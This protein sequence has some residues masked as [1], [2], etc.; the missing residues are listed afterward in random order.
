[1][2]NHRTHRHQRLYVTG[3]LDSNNAE[4]PGG[5]VVFDHKA[6]HIAEA[7][8]GAQECVPGTH[9]SEPPRIFREY[10][11]ALALMLLR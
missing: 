10:A 2:R 7:E 1:V 9:V 6:R 3:Q 4:F 5:N 11:E 8:A